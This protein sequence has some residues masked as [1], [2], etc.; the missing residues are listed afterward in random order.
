MKG[1]LVKIRPT[2][3]RPTIGAQGV[4]QGIIIRSFSVLLTLVDHQKQ[5][6]TDHNF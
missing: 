3:N 4:E 6:K 1:D 5:T 2:N